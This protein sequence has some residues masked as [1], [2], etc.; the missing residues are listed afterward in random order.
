[1]TTLNALVLE[2]FE[3]SEY[4]NLTS[5]FPNVRCS[6]QLSENPPNILCS[7]VH[8]QKCIMNIAI[9]SAE[10]IKGSGEI[11]FRTDQSA[12]PADWESANKA[13]QEEYAVLIITDTGSGISDKDIKH[14]FEPFYTKKK[15]GRSGSGLGLA[16]VWNTLKEH[17]GTVDVRS[18]PKGSSFKLY[19]P[20]T[21]EPVELKQRCQDELMQGK[22]ETILVVDDEPQ[23]LDIASSMLEACGYNVS[24]VNSGE[25]AVSYLQ[26]QRVDIVLIDMLMEPGINGR[27]TYEHILQIHPGQ[28]AIIASG[29]AENSEVRK[30][31][32][33]G[34][35]VF[36]K[37][38]YSMA[39]IAKAVKDVLGCRK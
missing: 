23:L 18:T 20:V 25:E 4:H 21:H 24:T 6:Y 5:I 35:S 19:F 16:V 28:K 36:I 9:N 32:S 29:F 37:K 8:V 17:G 12:P 22:G 30:T 7:P 2:Y 27:E 13:D 26:N 10:A 15:M 34:A 1:V 33:L 38:P 39:D 14:I 3:S 11:I 31:L